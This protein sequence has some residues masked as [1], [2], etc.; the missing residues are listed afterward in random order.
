MLEQNL[1]IVR[2]FKPM[3]A[4]REGGGEAKVRAHAGDG[5]FELFKIV[6]DLR[7]PRSPQ[8]ARVCDRDQLRSLGPPRFV[9]MIEPYVNGD[10][11]AVF[12]DAARG[13]YLEIWSF[14]DPGGQSFG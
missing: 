10:R 6:Q 8:A 2:E 5:R 12:D 7:R 13:A 14:A 1:K 4:G 11:V 3:T 9:E